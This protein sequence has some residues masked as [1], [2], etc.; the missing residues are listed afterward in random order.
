MRDL[1]KVKLDGLEKTIIVRAKLKG[2]KATE[3]T[4]LQR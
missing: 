1:V 2:I 4:T 3:M